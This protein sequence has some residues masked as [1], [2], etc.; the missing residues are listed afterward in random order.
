M[1]HYRPVMEQSTTVSLSAVNIETRSM[2]PRGCSEIGR[3]IDLLNSLASAVIGM[4]RATRKGRVPELHDAQQAIRNIITDFAD[5]PDAL[6][7]ALSANRGMYHLCRRAVGCTVL[8]LAM[9]RQL[10]MPP[11]ALQELMLG[12]VLLDI[13]KLRVPVVILAKTGELNEAE[14]KF[15]R[16]HVNAGVRILEPIEGLSPDVIEM[17]RSHHERLDGSGFPC[18]LK[19]D[20][21]SLYAQIAGIIDSYDAMSLSRYY[22]DG[23]SGTDAINNLREISGEKFDAGLIEQF[24]KA[25]GDVPVGTWVELPDGS[26][27][28]V[29]ARQ[30]NSDDNDRSARVALIADEQQQPYLAV[31]WLS[32]HKHS[33]ARILTPKERPE[34]APA[35]ERSLQSAIYAFQPRR[36]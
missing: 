1:Q 35:M 17:V 23:L 31:R 26:T 20:E 25:M 34:H 5:D 10:E 9:G 22:A 18:R 13:G 4:H 16:R 36:D 33:D 32:L 14:H 27:G 7:W 6:F 2:G 3:A 28:V 19:G 11:E 12:A 24:S 30:A 8:A 29:C 21:I 15:A